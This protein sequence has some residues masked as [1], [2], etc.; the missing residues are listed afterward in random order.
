MNLARRLGRPSNRWHAAIFG[1][2]VSISGASRILFACHVPVFRYALERWPADS[3]RVTV[4]HRG[5]GDEQ[6]RGLRRRW[7]DDFRRRALNARLRTIDLDQA[8]SEDDA[9]LWAEQKNPPLP[10]LVV[11]YPESL[12]NDAA[13]WS[14]P[15]TDANM[16]QV[17][18]SPARSEVARRLCTG[19]TAVWLLLESGDAAKDAAAAGLLQ[20]ESERLAKTL[21]L[22]ALS[23][24]PEDGLWSSLPLTVSF[25]LLEL[26]RSEP[27][28]NFLV[29]S[30]LHAEE[31]SSNEPVV[32]PIYGRGRALPALAG[33]GITAESIEEQ[34]RFLVGACSCE[35]KDLNP[36]F[37]LLLAADWDELV[38]T[39]TSRSDATPSPASSTSLPQYLAIPPGA[40]PT[41]SSHTESEPLSS[42]DAAP[43]LM[44]GVSL[45]AVITTLALILARRFY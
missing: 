25:S 3:Y 40:S 5:R 18:A 33:T 17:P 10:W 44:T 9:A 11:Q 43:Y 8:L 23:A 12:R 14:G 6:A 22:P 41:A 1:V 26:S 20:R 29:N 21:K 37:D 32:F 4:I 27:A 19:E 31:D 42:T 7:E 13:L 38:L 45:F 36:G 24:E 15:F 28:E 2:I 39:T 34:A 30:L 35:L 16:D